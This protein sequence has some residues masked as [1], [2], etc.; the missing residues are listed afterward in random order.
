MAYVPTPQDDE[1]KRRAAA[2]APG[3]FGDTAPAAPTTSPKFVNVAEYL[4]KN[5]EASAQLGEAGSAKLTQQRTEAEGA[6]TEAGNKFT[7]DVSAGTTNLDQGMLDTALSNPETFVQSPENTAKF[8]AMRDASY[9]GPTSLQSTS[10]FAPAQSKVT[11]LGT[12]ATGLGTEAGRSALVGSL[13]D[14]PTAGKTS[15]NQLLLQGNA[16]AAQKIQDTAGTFKNVEDQWNQLLQNAPQSAEAA[17][18]ATD[19]ART[20]TQSR[21]GDTTNTF[22]TGLSNKLATATNERDAFNLDYQNIDNELAKGGTGL[23][24]AQLDKLGI[25]DAYPYLSKLE[26]FNRPTALGYY[27]APTPLTNYVQPGTPNS[28]VPT[29]G[30]VASPEDYAREAA[31]QQLSGNDLGLAD[32]PENAYTA[33]GRLPT[34]DYMGA[35]GQAGTSLQNFDK[36]W[37]PKVAGYAPDDIS[38]LYAV[39]GRQGIGTSTPGSYYTDPHAGATPSGGFGIAPAPTGWDSNTPPPYPQPTSNPPGQLVNP[40]WNPYTG[41]WQG[42]QLQPNTPP[43]T[44]GGGRRVTY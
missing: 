22:K 36:N 18:A 37:T 8:L 26:Q 34:V 17:R 16:G 39:Q 43:P 42:A 7:Q 19:A 40:T 41:Q 20:T 38:Q 3:M 24:Q 13:S 10:Y 2:G 9:K 27:N 31:L 44:S 1:E 30:G 4:S 32:Q 15:L 21:L 6:V 23:S 29:M 33:N 5:P 14:H 12:T 11:G 28:N 25:K 35:F